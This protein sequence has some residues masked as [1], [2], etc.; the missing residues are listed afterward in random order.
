ME[1]DRAA[2]L[3]PALR[4]P[5]PGFDRAAQLIA[6]VAAALGEAAAE[7]QSLAAE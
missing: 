4:E 3:D 5:G 2:Y 1:I 6:V 7:T